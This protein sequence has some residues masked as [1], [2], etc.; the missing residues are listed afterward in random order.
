MLPQDDAR[1]VSG[2]D[3]NAP[4]SAGGQLLIEK[5]LR[6]ALKQGLV[7]MANGNLANKG[8]P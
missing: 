6:C 4:D 2:R 1:P 3:V 8:K 7:G 5:Q